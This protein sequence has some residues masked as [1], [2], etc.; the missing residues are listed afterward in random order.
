MVGRGSFGNP[1]LFKEISDLLI[2]GEYKKSFTVSE[3]MAVM[4]E[5]MGKMFSFYPKEVAAKKGRS[6]TMRYF[7]GFKN[8]TKL[9]KMCAQITDYE[10]ILNCIKCIE[11]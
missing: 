3:R 8:A 1:F 5:H 10:D 2:C 9:R 11:N 6:Q 4:L 7:Y